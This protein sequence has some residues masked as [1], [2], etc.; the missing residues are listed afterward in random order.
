MTLTIIEP[1]AETKLTTLEMVKSE[2]RLSGTAEDD[3]LKVLIDQ[4]TDTIQTWCRRVF[5]RETLSEK[6]Y[7]TVPAR[8]LVLSRWPVISVASVTVNGTAVDLETV[9]QDAGG[10]LYQ[11]DANGLRST[12]PSGLIAVEYVAGYLLPGE[13]GRTLPHDIE[14]A[15]INLI[16]AI[17]YART[18]DP[19]IRS[20]SIE[21]LGA[22]TYQVGGFRGG[23][24]L[25]PDV[26]GLLARYA[27]AG[28]P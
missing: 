27:G 12:W 3:F 24:G 13:E 25:P 7:P 8:S 4:A 16:K 15:M 1:A 19:M 2:I 17:W 18:R 9:E 23:A 22:T 5:S 14:R 20:D 28:T 11:L 6:L 10:Y 21:G 26:E